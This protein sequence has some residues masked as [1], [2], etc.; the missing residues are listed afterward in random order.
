MNDPRPTDGFRAILLSAAKFVLYPTF[1]FVVLLGSIYATFPWERVKDR[2]E[3]EFAKTQ[4]GKGADAWRLEVGSLDGYWLTGVELR[5]SKIIIPPDTDDGK[6]APRATAGQ[7]RGALASIARKAATQKAAEEEAKPSAKEDE[8]DKEKEKKPRESILLIDHAHARV[9]ILPLLIGR[10]RVD[11]GADIFGGEINGTVPVGGGDLTVAA[12]NIDL[13]QVAPLAETISVPLKGI[14][15]ANLELSAVNGKW[16]KSTGSFSLSVADMVVGD[17]KAKFRGLK[18][19]PAAALGTF[20]IEAKAAEGVLKIEKFGA[21]GRDLDVAGVGTIKLKDSWQASTADLYMRF[22]FSDEYKNSNEDTKTLFVDD[23]PFPALVN[24]DAKLKRAKRSDGNW[25]FHV[26]GRLGRLRYDPTTADGPKGMK[27]PAATDSPAAPRKKSTS[28][29]AEEE[30]DDDRPKVATP[31]T[32]RPREIV[33]PVRI[34]TPPSEPQ[35]DPEQQ[36]PE[37]QTPEP[38]VPEPQAPEPQPE[39]AIREDQP[40]QAPPDPGQ[41]QPPPG[42]D[43][44]SP[45]Q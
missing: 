19:L 23:G 24:L 30:S 14:A 11:F 5:D 39:P 9:R 12:E 38:Q 21:G 33:S 40:D 44:P 20:E 1:Y 42:E 43:S 7:P 41:Q 29:A 6:A 10:V 45:P 18:P 3:A 31:P 36:A 27:L 28:P 37:P 2:V 17:G 35:H 32:P 25:G 34:G 8:P 16:S 4:A 13:G 26:H 22:G 15:N